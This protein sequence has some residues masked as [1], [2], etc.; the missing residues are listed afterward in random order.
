LLAVVMDFCS[1][2]PMQYR[3]GVD[4]LDWP[5]EPIGARPI[6]PTLGLVPRSLP[7]PAILHEHLDG[8]PNG[9]SG[10]RAGYGSPLWIDAQGSSGSILSDDL[11][12]SPH[13]DVQ[14]VL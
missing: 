9:E 8:L 7:R 12:R 3:S 1:G 4:T 5:V 10:F 11:P 14:S 2:P 13:T 6:E